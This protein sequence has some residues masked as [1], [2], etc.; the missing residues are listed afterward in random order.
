MKRTSLLSE[1]GAPA[2]ALFAACGDAKPKT[3]RKDLRTAPLADRMRLE[4]EGVP[5]AIVR[6]LISEMD[7]ST[8]HFQR[9]VGMPK[10][11]FTKKMK[12]QSMFAGTQGHT[13]IGILELINRVEDMIAPESKSA[14]TQKFDV[15][16]WVGDW[17]SKPQPALGGM[18]PADLLDTPSGRESVMRVVGSLQSGAYQ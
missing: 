5:Y 8:T 16:K 18:T 2:K 7:V 1:Q 9:M 3:F 11:T 12:E 15:E 14:E 4:R 13:V 10:A 6:A 17:V